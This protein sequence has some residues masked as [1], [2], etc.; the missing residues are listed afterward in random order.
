MKIGIA[1][2]T[3]TLLLAHPLSATP[4]TDST[5]TYS[6]V[7][8]ADTSALV[9]SFQTPPKDARPQVWW[10]WMDGNV[11]KEGIRKDIEWM[12]RNG[13]GGFHQFDA[14]GVNMPRAAKVKLPYLSDGWKDAFR[15]A[16][17]LADSLDMD[18]T[19]ASAPGWSS[20]GGTWVKPED[21]IK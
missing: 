15:F 3:L 13:I 16:L 18:V 14:G 1:L 6:L 7:R 5:Q 11:S 10:H 4:D 20:T 8:K 19:I 21:A 2:T 12:K 9:K 17:N